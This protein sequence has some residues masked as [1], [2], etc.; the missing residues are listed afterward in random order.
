M[1]YV[2]TPTFQNSNQYTLASI[3]Q[4][5]AGGEGQAGMQAVASVIQ[6]RASQN[7]SGYGTSAISQALANNQFQ[8][9]STPSQSALDIAAQLQN[10]TLADNT[11]GATYYANPAASTASWA[12]NLN[13]S[14]SLQIGNH[15]FTNNTNGTPFMPDASANQ[16]SLDDANSSGA[17]PL[18]IHPGNTPDGNGNG[19]TST[20]AA[21]ASP[22][23][24]SLT[25]PLGAVPSGTVPQAID[26]QTAQDKADTAAAD[27]A[28][29]SAAQSTNATNA[30][31][32]SSNQT[33]GQNLFVR[34]GF[35]LLGLI[36]VALGLAYLFP[37]AVPIPVPR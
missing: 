18:T 25:P 3:I 35:V 14:N 36:F 11:G 19:D 7:F 5:E 21:S 15:F 9:Q 30:A 26:A 13:S 32:A 8:G 27:A 29:T 28:T 22:T 12:T 17:P 31:V 33:Y 1:A 2:G 6:N 23:A 20:N 4:G 34:A 10:G 16:P 24:N 37:R